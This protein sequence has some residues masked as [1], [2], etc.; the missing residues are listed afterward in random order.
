[1]IVFLAKHLCL[2]KTSQFFLAAGLD[3]AT[4]VFQATFNPMDVASQTLCDNI[5]I[6]DDELAN[7]PNE[8]FSLSLQSANP[9]G[10]FVLNE[11]CI[12]IIDN[13]GESFALSFI[14]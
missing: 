1:M 3:Y 10:V 5:Q 9:T 11:T 13:D 12:T 2:V 6:F 4:L 14:Y 7:E 8:E